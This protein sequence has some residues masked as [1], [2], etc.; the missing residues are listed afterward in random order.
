MDDS[1]AI[2]PEYNPEEHRLSISISG[3]NEPEVSKLNLYVIY[4]YI[5]S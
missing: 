2:I 3:L 1:L 4:L 5:Y